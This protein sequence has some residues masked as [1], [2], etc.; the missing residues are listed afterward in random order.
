L[1]CVA[2]AYEARHVAGAAVVI[3]ATDDPAVNRRAAADA[4]AAG[5]LVNV[6][7][8]PEQCDFIVPAQVRRGDLVV[9]VTTGG[10]APSLS[11]R[12]RERLEEEFGPEWAPYLEALRAA[13]ERIMAEGHAP[14]V[15]RRLF[16]RLTEPDVLAAA[17]EGPDALRRAMDAAVA[18][19]GRM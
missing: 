4:R 19:A 1:E 3:A 9:A 8:V 11:R 7:D 17:R 12:L 2:E 16:E 6:V 18:E 15:R 5:V 13:R 10:A 14:E